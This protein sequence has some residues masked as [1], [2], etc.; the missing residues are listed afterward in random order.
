[1]ELQEAIKE[2]KKEYEN[3][4]RKNEENE[5]IDKYGSMFNPNK[6]IL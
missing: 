1:M 6:L 2:T 3:I 4:E 5:V